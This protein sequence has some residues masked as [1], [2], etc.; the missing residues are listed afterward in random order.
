MQKTLLLMLMVRIH[1]S[2]SSLEEQCLTRDMH[3]FANVLSEEKVLVYDLFHLP[4]NRRYM[5][6]TGLFSGPHLL[7]VSSEH[8]HFLVW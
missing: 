1:Y 6:L 2:Y 4:T 7:A 8:D 3:D 5:R